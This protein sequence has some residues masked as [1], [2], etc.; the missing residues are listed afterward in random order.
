MPLYRLQTL[1]QMPIQQCTRSLSTLQVRVGQACVC[2]IK[3]RSI[4]SYC[5]FQYG[6]F[7]TQHDIIFGAGSDLYKISIFFLQ[8]SS[9]LEQTPTCSYRFLATGASAA[10]HY[11]NYQ[12]AKMIDILFVLTSFTVALACISRA[13]IDS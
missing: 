9:L 11:P 10:K 6:A 2:A 4:V 8:T 12:A 5:S 3:A 13:L 7:L 1:M